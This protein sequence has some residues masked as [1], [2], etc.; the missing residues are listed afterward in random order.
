MQVALLAALAAV[1]P[2]ATFYCTGR[3]KVSNICAGIKL[4]VPS[5][6]VFKLIL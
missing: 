2:R 3:L 4:T 6:G 1:R 5:L